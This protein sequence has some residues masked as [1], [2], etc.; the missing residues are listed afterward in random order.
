MKITIHAAT[1]RVGSENTSSFEIDKEEWE[2][3]DE[4]QRSEFMVEQFWESGLV[5]W[6]W[7][8]K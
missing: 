4:E 6:W 1:N 2:A 8:E 3:M 5:D 7:D